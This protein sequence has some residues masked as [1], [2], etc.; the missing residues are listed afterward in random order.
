[1][2]SKEI[3]KKICIELIYFENHPEF[4]KSYISTQKDTDY[5]IFT[6]SVP[7]VILNENEK[8]N[9]SIFSKIEYVLDS[10]E[11]LPS[12]IKFDKDE[13]GNF[14]KSEE[15]WY[16]K[17]KLFRKDDV[18]VIMQYH[19]SSQIKK[20]FY[21]IHKVRFR[22]NERNS[23][24]DYLPNVIEYHPNGKLKSE[25]YYFDKTILKDKDIP[26]Y[27]LYDKEGNKRREIYTNNLDRIDRIDGPAVIDYN[28]TNSG[29]EIEEKY[30]R[31]GKRVKE[32]VYSKCTIL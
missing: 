22:L 6:R 28:Y 2:T 25:Y 12:F 17:G 19:P 23:T 26:S 14:Y 18:P 32:R 30:Y 9:D 4:K 27:I 3:S 1:M 29:F 10:K 20:L 24:Y 5:L 8:F 15:R 16:K 31:D 13:E 11:N 7:M 21:N